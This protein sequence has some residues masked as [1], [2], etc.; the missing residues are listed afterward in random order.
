MAKFLDLVVVG[1]TIAGFVALLVYKLVLMYRYRDDPEKLEG[2]AWTDQM[3]PKRIQRFM[4]DEDY[5]K[6]RKASAPKSHPK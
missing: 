1:L 2:L 4:Y 6:A 5:D 3:F